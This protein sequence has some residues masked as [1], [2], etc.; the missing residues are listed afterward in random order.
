MEASR[1]RKLTVTDLPCDDLENEVYE[2]LGYKAMF[3]RVLPYIRDNWHIHTL[4]RYLESA[5]RKLQRL[6]EDD[7][8]ITGVLREEEETDIEEDSVVAYDDLTILN[9]NNHEI[10]SSIY[11]IQNDVDYLYG[12]LAPARGRRLTTDETESL[13][14]RDWNPRFPF[15]GYEDE[16]YIDLEALARTK[17]ALTQYNTKEARLERARLREEQELADFELPDFYVY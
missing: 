11:F 3:D 14:D 6:E 1:K 2:W 10:W 12:V 16:S 9:E 15:R 8:T 4:G 7:Y 17:E 13:M 5:R